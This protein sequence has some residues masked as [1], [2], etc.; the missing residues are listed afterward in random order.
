MTAIDPKDILL[1]DLQTIRDTIMRNEDIGEKRFSFF[2]SLITAAGAGLAALVTSDEFKGSSLDP[3]AAS[4]VTGALAVLLVFSVLTYLR[5][6]YRN[7]VARGFEIMDRHICD[8]AR[9]LCEPLQNM[10]YRLPWPRKGPTEKWFVAGYAQTV[11]VFVGMLTGALTAS[12]I[13]QMD[14][15]IGCALTAAIF[16]GLSVT[17]LLWVLATRY[18]GYK[19]T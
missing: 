5:M 2:I 18:H 16:A 10:D 17:V 8:A 9:Q 1:A 4:I 14:G 7:K 12:V 13:H 11:A 3:W 19:N 15:A 6:L